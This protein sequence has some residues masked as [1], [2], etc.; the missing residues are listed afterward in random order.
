MGPG[1]EAIAYIANLADIRFYIGRLFREG[2]NLSISSEI[3]LLA[4]NNGGYI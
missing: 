3:I 4:A 2:G 1:I